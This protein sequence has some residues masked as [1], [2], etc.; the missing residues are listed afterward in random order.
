[1]MK[2]SKSNYFVLLILLSSINLI[3]YSIDIPLGQQYSS[4]GNHIFFSNFKVLNFNNICVLSVLVHS[5]FLSYTTTID[6]HF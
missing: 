6:H 5:V 4:I 3:I 2:S 1:M